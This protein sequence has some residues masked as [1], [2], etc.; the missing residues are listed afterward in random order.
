ML[1]KPNTIPKTSSGKIMR[2]AIRADFL[3]NKLSERVFA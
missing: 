1:L 2:S 3:Q